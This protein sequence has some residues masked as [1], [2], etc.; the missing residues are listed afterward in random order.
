M[1]SVRPNRRFKQE[2]NTP[3]GAAQWQEVA[4]NFTRAGIR[5]LAPK[6]TGFLKQRITADKSRV[7][8]SVRFRST[9][10]EPPYDLYQE[11]GT[12]LYGPLNRWITPKRARF[13]SWIASPR[14]TRFFG[15]SNQRIYGQGRRVFAKRVRGVPPRHYFK[16]ALERLYGTSNVDYYGDTGG[17]PP[18]KG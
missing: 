13:L 12:G 5:V 15:Q 18:Q 14:G 6:D 3:A 1:G 17:R 10:G 7:T 8:A 11:V 4:A 16:R 9:V 2:V